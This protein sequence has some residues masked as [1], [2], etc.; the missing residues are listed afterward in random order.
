MTNDATIASPQQPL[1]PPSLPTPTPIYKEC[2]IDTNG[3]EVKDRLGILMVKSVDDLKADIKA[4]EGKMDEVERI[5]VEL[6][7]LQ[8]TY[9]E[10]KAAS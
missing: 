3:C 10:R 6:E 8:K 1:V 9:T 5:R 4:E 7:K 2:N